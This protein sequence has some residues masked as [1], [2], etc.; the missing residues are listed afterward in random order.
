MRSVSFP[1]RIAFE[2]F[3]PRTNRIASA[4]LLL[5]DPFGPVIAVKPWR[6]GT[7]I[8]RPND[9][10]FSIWISFRNKVSPVWGKVSPGGNCHYPSH[11]YL[12]GVRRGSDADAEGDNGYKRV[13]GS[14][15]RLDKGPR[16]ILSLCPF[17]PQI[18]PLLGLFGES[19]MSPPVHPQRWR[20][21]SWGLDAGLSL[22]RSWSPSSRCF[23][24]SLRR[25][26]LRRKH[27]SGRPRP[28]SPAGRCGTWIPSP[29]LGTLCCR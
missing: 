21:S 19:L 15:G 5:P 18:A 6:N 27:D 3:G 17:Q 22:V 9:L 11:L 10:K 7:V 14:S 25:P 24:F 13:A 29:N 1:A 8:F 2:L 4:M 16:Q 20:E 23:A 26:S 28:I 12:S